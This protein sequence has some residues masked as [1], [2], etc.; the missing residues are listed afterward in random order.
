MN[1][2]ENNKPKKEIG[3]PC[4]RHS[5]LLYCLKVIEQVEYDRQK[6]LEEEAGVTYIWEDEEDD[7]QSGQ[8]V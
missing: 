6:Y 7:E 5:A 8:E 1:K 3:I 4:S 2:A